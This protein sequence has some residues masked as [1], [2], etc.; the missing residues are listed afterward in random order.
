M[1]PPPAI[2]CRE[3]AVLKTRTGHAQDLNMAFTCNDCAKQLQRNIEEVVSRLIGETA[4]GRENRFQDGP[5]ELRDRV[6]NEVALLIE[7]LKG[8]ADFGALYTGQRAFELTH[9]E[10][11]REENLAIYRREVESDGHI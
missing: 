11:T 4:R 9:L 7:F 3:E 5:D 8:R 1:T 6:R 10:K 2:I